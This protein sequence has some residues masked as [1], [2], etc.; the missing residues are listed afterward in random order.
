MEWIFE[1]LQLVFLAIIGVVA[2]LKTMWEAKAKAEAETRARRDFTL[3]RENRVPIDDDTSYRKVLRPTMPS[4][5]P[6]IQRAEIPPPLPSSTPT[7]RQSPAPS[8]SS[9]V[10]AA[11]ETARMLQHQQDLAERLRQI[12]DTKASTS[13]GAAATKAHAAARSQKRPIPAEWQASLRQRLGN[14]SEVRRAL[15]MSEILGKPLSLR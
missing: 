7:R 1:H 8:V 9:N 11:A 2:L 5:P 15:I 3:D 12:R 4:V 13:R 10:S 6:P 14:A